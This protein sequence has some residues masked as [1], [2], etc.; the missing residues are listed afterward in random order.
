MEP[1]TELYLEF[2]NIVL[3]YFVDLNKEMLSESPKLYLLYEK[4]FVTYKT[5]LECFMMPEYLELTEQEKSD[6]QVHDK[7]EALE[8]KILV[9]DFEKTENHLLLEDI[10]LGGNVAAL[11]IKNRSSIHPD[12]TS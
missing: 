9:L 7:A 12:K 5:I 10:Y 1:T 4:I 11:I 8:T 6:I 3:P 2:L